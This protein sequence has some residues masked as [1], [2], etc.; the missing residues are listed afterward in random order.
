M[1]SG[2]RSYR[3]GTGTGRHKPAATP[4]DP[5]DPQRDMTIL[6]LLQQSGYRTLKGFYAHCIPIH[7]GAKSPTSSATS[8]FAAFMPRVPLQ[9]AACLQTRNSAELRSETSSSTAAY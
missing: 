1:R 8:R 2:K 6:I 3:P 4:H 5:A 9:L 7:L